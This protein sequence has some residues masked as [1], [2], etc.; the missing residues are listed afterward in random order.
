MKTSFL[1]IAPITPLLVI[2]Q[3]QTLICIYNCV[4]KIIIECFYIIGSFFF[5][6]PL[7]PKQL[8]TVFHF[9]F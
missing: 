7:L 9:P 1:V 6:N 3:P 5:F 4:M 2:I 8:F